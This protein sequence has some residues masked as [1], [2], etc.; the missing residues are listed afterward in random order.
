MLKR[1]LFAAAALAIVAGPASAAC[2]YNVAVLE[3]ATADGAIKTN[4]ALMGNITKAR[5]LAN[6]GKEKEC[7]VVVH[8]IYMDLDKTDDGRMIDEY[9]TKLGKQGRPVVQ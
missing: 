1:T 5:G 3:S 7:M 6:D 8:E 2:T 9:H 4:D